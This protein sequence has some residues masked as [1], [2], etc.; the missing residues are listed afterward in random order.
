ML[1]VR[2]YYCSYVISPCACTMYANLVK[3]NVETSTITIVEIQSPKKRSSYKTLMKLA[4]S[5][6]A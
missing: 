4:Y 6:I 1:T 3:G 2:Y 5:G